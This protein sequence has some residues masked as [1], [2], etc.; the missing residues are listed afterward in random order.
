MRPSPLFKLSWT[1]RPSS[2]PLPSTMT[3]SMVNLPTL[4]LETRWQEMLVVVSTTNSVSRYNIPLYGHRVE[5]IP[6]FAPCVFGHT[7][8]LRGLPHLSLPL[9]S[10]L[11]EDRKKEARSRTPSVPPAFFSLT[12]LDAAI[13]HSPI[14]LIVFLTTLIILTSASVVPTMRMSH[15]CT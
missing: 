5:S 10:L 8:H 4:V 6:L 12:R 13:V 14:I 3:P 15:Y 9:L 11:W 7:Q 1:M 2:I